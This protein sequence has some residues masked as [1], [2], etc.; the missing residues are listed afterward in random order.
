MNLCKFKNILGE[1]N[2][3][4]HSYKI[5][6]IAVVDLLLTIFISLL[7][8]YFFKY[9]FIIILIIMLISGVI[10]HRIFCVKTTV[11]KWLFPA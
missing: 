11:D 8:S 5:F 7:I 4:I 3:G 10:F 2:N 9:N 1:P 6:N